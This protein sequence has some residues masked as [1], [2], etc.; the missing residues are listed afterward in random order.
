[1]PPDSSVPQVW[2]IAIDPERPP[3]A[4]SVAL[5]GTD[6]LGQ[7][8]TAAMGLQSGGEIRVALVA[9][10]PSGLR[11]AVEAVSGATL[12]LI[13]P[14]DYTAGLAEELGEF[15]LTIFRNYLPA[16]FPSG[17]VLVVEPP[18]SGE[19]LRVGEDAARLVR[20]GSRA[21]P[22]G[23]PV[24]ILSP[25][26]LVVGIDFSGVRWARA[27]EVAS[28]PSGFSP[29]LEAGGIP[30]LLYEEIRHSAQNAS[31]VVVLLADLTQGNFTKHPAFPIL[32][33]NL[34]QFS[35]QSP[36]PAQVQTGEPIP[37]PAPGAYGSVDV[38]P[39]VED[40]V[41][42]SRDWP[43]EWEQT[44]T[45]GLYRFRFVENDGD[46][47]EYLTG[48]NAGDPEESDLR[49]RS[50]VESA[51]AGVE[52]PSNL[53][54]TEEKHFDLWP[55]LLAAAVLALLAQAVLAWRR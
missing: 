26:P 7:D 43:S 55:W 50:W 27:W 37:L 29:G 52:G 2:E 13:S 54:I 3:A 49:P 53:R 34:V 14:A 15:D 9:E 36:L 47:R 30:L 51:M 17:Q 24:R 39:P 23:A 22:P 16:E 48:A 44:F 19:G 5:L 45:P 41:G 11:Q 42:F 31:R 35:R 46:R 32:I 6:G 18:S 21:V 1:M 12:T 25:D 33:A 28:P 10:N 8:D 38:L 20:T 4:V 40:A